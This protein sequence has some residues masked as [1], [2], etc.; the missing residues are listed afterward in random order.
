M[1]RSA[2]TLSQ[3]KLAGGNGGP[4]PAV[5]GTYA[6]QDVTFERGEGS[7]LISAAGDRYLDFASGV[8]VNAQGWGRLHREYWVRPRTSGH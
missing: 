5:M 3:P 1:S 7:W 6:R 4:S 8:A 2:T